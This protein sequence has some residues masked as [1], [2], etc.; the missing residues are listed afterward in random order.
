M[1]DQLPKGRK[2]NDSYSSTASS[3]ESQFISVGGTGEQIPQAEPISEVPA[4]PAGREISG[5]SKRSWHF[6]EV[7]GIFIA[8]IM[9]V[10]GFAYYL[11]GLNNRLTGVEDQIE[12]IELTAEE[13]ND[14]FESD[15]SEIEQRIEFRLDARLNSIERQLSDMSSRIDS[16][17]DARTRRVV[18][19]PDQQ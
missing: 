4:T 12:A 18:S 1:S 8:I 5:E 16:L 3:D 14:N 2:P 13:S 17:L 10:A 6:L 9:A 15:L 7:V 11:G 19:E